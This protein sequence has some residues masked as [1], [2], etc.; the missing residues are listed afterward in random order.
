MDIKKVVVPS[1]GGSHVVK[2]FWIGE[3]QAGRDVW[4]RLHIRKRPSV[5]QMD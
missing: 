5:C 1:I 3:S 4:W 2:V